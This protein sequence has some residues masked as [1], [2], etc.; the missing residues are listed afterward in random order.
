[1]GPSGA[2]RTDGREDGCNQ[3]ADRFCLQVRAMFQ[4]HSNE[5]GPVLQA[6]SCLHSY[7]FACSAFVL[8]KLTRVRANRWARP[9]CR[10]HNVSKVKSIKRWFTCDYCSRHISATGQKMYASICSG[11]HKRPPS[12]SRGTMRRQNSKSSAK[13]T[14][15]SA[16]LELTGGNSKCQ[17][18]ALTQ[19]R[20]EYAVTAV[21]ARLI[22]PT[23][24]SH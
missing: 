21:V 22:S 8:T 10:H 19:G 16:G 13:K 12:W 18:T 6:V 24:L 14:L 5:A 9:P 1:M 15:P 2:A 23:S 20:G 17:S 3:R 11:C 7:A 4:D